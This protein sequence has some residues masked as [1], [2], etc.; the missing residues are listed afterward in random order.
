MEQ[1]PLLKD[2][3]ETPIIFTTK[4]RGKIIPLVGSRVIFEFI[5]KATNQK[6]G[7]G[8]CEIVDAGLGQVRYTFKAPELA[9]P[10]DYQGRVTIDLSQ[11]AKREGL[12][13]EFVVINR[14]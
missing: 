10:G 13:L 11:G 7:G 6:I 14:P 8:D 12:A 9:H 5:S 1:I 4:T 2:D 3:Y